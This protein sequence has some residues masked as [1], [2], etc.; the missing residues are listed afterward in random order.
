MQVL[1]ATICVSHTFEV[2]RQ[3]K[4]ATVVCLWYFDPVR[5]RR[6]NSSPNP[7]PRTYLNLRGGMGVVLLGLISSPALHLGR[8]VGALRQLC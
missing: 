5:R 2:V 4:L 6:V 1:D 7:K 8:G 3:A